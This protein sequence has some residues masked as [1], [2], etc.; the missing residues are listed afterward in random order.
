MRK[1]RVLLAVIGLVTVLIIDGALVWHYLR[2]QDYLSEIVH[3]TDRWAVIEDVQGNHLAVEPTSGEVW[4]VLVELHQN[5]T[6][7]W[8]GGAVERYENKWGF[9]LRPENITVAQFTAEG[10]QATI[11]FVSE[12]LDYWLNL[13]LV[14][15]GSK[16]IEIH[17]PPTT[18][19]TRPT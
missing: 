12:N 14:Y 1:F 6:E 2:Y 18:P 17:H 13:G 11:Q 5:Q 9:R 10:L 15:I 7:M 19:Q 8:V 4:N 3:E 16:V